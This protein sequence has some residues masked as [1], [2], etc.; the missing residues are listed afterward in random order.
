MG[1]YF[2]RS[3]LTHYKWRQRWRHSLSL[4]LSHPSLPIELGGS[5]QRASVCLKRKWVKCNKYLQ[6]QGKIINCVYKRLSERRQAK[7]VTR[8]MIG[9]FKWEIKCPSLL[10][11]TNLFQLSP[12]WCL[13]PESVWH[14]WLLIFLLLSAFLSSPATQTKAQTICLLINHENWWL[15]VKTNQEENWW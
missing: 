15:K 5:E 6:V 1:D 7:T 13:S 11:Y 9:W 10:E 4:S 3:P 12:G 14:R 8:L 2:C